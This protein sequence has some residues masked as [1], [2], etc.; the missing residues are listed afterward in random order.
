MHAVTRTNLQTLAEVQERPC[1]S[2]FVYMEGAAN[3][4]SEAKLKLRHLIHTARAEL[5]D[6]LA[7]NQVDTLLA[8]A[9]QLLS[10]QSPW[11][12][13]AGGMA[14]FLAPGQALHVRLPAAVETTVTVSEHFDVLPLIPMLYPD[15]LFHIL[16]LSRSA[17]TVC[18]AT[19]HTIQIL[20]V[21][22]MPAGLDE[23]W[24]L[25]RHEDA[26]VKEWQQERQEMFERYLRTVDDVLGPMLFATG[27]PM[28]LAAVERE[29]STFRSISHH[30]NLCDVALLGNPDEL[31]AA[32]LHE[33][34]WH[35]VRDHLETTQ[36]ASVLTRFDEAGGTDKR[37]VHM[38]EILDAAS[39]GRVE[40][41]LIP[42]PAHTGSRD[43][44]VNRAII[45]TLRHDGHIVLVPSSRLPA[46]ASVGAMFRWTR[47]SK[48][49]Y[50]R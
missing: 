22:G 1:V 3:D 7:E 42:E 47:E 45:E 46:E 17:V 33:Q 20:H 25:T 41:L 21:P 31:T 38:T 44:W 27:H 8:P 4:L 5:A 13:E 32:Q 48:D 19:R 24:L 39:E 15:C 14:L 28:V 12:G 37:S 29:V 43:G 16:A 40:A 26:L 23:S 9:E 35:V 30:P 36:Q 6:C 49:N 11:P 10:D 18:E 50:A 2:M 34:A